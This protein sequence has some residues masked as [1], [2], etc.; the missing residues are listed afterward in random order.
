MPI[1]SRILEF[2]KSLLPIPQ[3]RQCPL[4]R[5]YGAYCHGSY[6][7]GVLLENGCSGIVC[8][9]RLLCQRCAQTYSLLPPHLLRRTKAELKLVI[10]AAQCHVSWY[11]LFEMSGAARNTIHRWKKLGR[12]L[13][14]VL[15][16]L[17]ESVHS[18]ADLSVHISR[19]QYPKFLRKLR[20]TIL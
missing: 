6:C 2:P 17:I 9:Q 10:K 14:N 15:P 5:K 11:A 4:C 3:K 16:V 12:S 7:R 18:W 13:L 8:V 19:W 1:L 20:P